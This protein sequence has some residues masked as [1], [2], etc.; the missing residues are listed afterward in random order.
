MSVHGLRH[1]FAREFLV[2]KYK[3]KL[4]EGFDR[5][6]AET[7]A[8]Q[9]T[10]LVMGHNRVS[11]TYVY[12]PEGLLRDVFQEVKFIKLNGRFGA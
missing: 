10:S 11:I 6:R 7:E 5:K 2:D 4:E 9:E 1:S 8:R 3:E 12:A